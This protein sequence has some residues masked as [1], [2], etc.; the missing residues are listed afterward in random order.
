MK[1]I[2]EEEI[3]PISKTSKRIEQFTRDLIFEA[4]L[5]RNLTNYI[6]A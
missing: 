5:R 4:D 1:S 2:Y 6:L 3:N